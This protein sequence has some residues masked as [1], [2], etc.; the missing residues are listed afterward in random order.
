MAAIAM[1]INSRI[2]VFIFVENQ[3]TRV[4]TKGCTTTNAIAK[5]IIQECQ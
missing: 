4:L 3:A 5:L 2:E 1:T